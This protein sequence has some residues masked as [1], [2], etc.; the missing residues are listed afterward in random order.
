MGVVVKESLK[1]TIVSY[2]GAGIGAAITLFVYPY[3]LSPE[4]V[5]LIRLLIDVATMFSFFALLGIQNIMIKFFSHFKQQHHEKA[6]ISFCFFIPLLGF[7]AVGGIVCLLSKPI[8]NAFAGNSQLFA[9]NFYYTLPLALT[10]VA[11]LLFE[12]LS[13][14]YRRI[15]VSR[16]MRD[17]LIRILTI[18][19]VILYFQHIISI[20]A[21]AVGI[22]IVYGIAA[23]ANGIYYHHIGIFSPSYS[24]N[25]MLSRKLVWSMTKFGGNSILA[26]LGGMLIGK[27]DVI[28]ISSEINLTNTGVYAIAFFIATMIEIP[29]RAINSLVVPQV[30]AEL[31]SGNIPKVAELYKK[32]TQN[33]LLISGTLLL[34]IWIN[35]D[36][37]FAIMPNGNLYNAGKYVVLFIGLGKF[38]DLT[39][40][41]NSAIIGYSKYYYFTPFC[42]IL[43]GILAIVSNLILIP[44]LGITGAAIASLTS[45]FIYNSIMVVLVQVLLKMQPFTWKC[46]Q[47]AIMLLAAFGVS[48]LLPSIDNPYV[49]FVVQFAVVGIFAIFVTMKFKLSEEAVDTI[50][51]VVRKVIGIIR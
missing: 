7:I 33:Q 3:F 34:L 18:A 49:S 48:L 50:K 2:I 22:A 30:S 23:V 21:L 31:N 24:S 29:A 6:F 1:G 46:L 37:F 44:K 8:I 17:I 20:T 9:D 14:I 42:T 16:F 40:G 19:L 28:M 38:V 47:I 4:E 36:N 39:T 5:G 13:T 11:L 51:M 25:K 32:I 12:T 27:I 10:M 35:I 43:L 26:G 15:F 45:L 41:I